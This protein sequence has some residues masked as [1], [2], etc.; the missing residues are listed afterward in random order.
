MTFE[1][2]RNNRDDNDNCPN[3]GSDEAESV[4]GYDYCICGVELGPSDSTSRLYA[5]PFQDRLPVEATA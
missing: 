4:D 3:C 1:D 5:V 2:N